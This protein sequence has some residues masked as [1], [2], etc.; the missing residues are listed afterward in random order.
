M[1]T[2]LEIPRDSKVSVGSVAATPMRYFQIDKA[3]RNWI[4][5]DVT[6][7]FKI[8]IHNSSSV[9]S[10]A[11][12]PLLWILTTCNR[13]TVIFSRISTK[14]PYVLKFLVMQDCSLQKPFPLMG[15]FRHVSNTSKGTTRC[16][17]VIWSEHRT[18]STTEDVGTA[19]GTTLFQ[20][21]AFT[22]DTRELQIFYLN[23]IFISIFYHLHLALLLTAMFGYL[24]LE[25]KKCNMYF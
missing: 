12:L 16:L 22:R 10:K 13:S 7:D 19:S 25:C 21:E 4:F 11:W 20:M 9:I 14:T 6:D 15:S 24:Y 23:V 17:P 3:P 5:V 18:V 2:A 1:S 8:C